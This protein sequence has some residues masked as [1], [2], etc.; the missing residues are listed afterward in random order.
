MAT[1][2]KP[3]TNLKRL[4]KA[5][6]IPKPAKPKKVSILDTDLLPLQEADELLKRIEAQSAE[7][8]I[9]EID[10]EISDDARKTAKSAMVHAQSQLQKLCDARKEQHPLFR[11]PATEAEARLNEENTRPVNVTIT[12][13]ADQHGLPTGQDFAIWLVKPGGLLV[14]GP[15]GNPV[16]ITDLEYSAVESV[17]KLID[18][19]RTSGV[20]S[21][22]NRWS[23]FVA[24][25]TPST[26]P[27]VKEG[28]KSLP[29]E[30]AGI[31]GRG[32]Q[33]LAEAGYGTLG[34]V[35]KLMQDHG[36]GW[37]KEVK[38]IGEETAADIADKFD[39]FWIPVTTTDSDG[40]AV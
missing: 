12:R 20:L 23:K 4:K 24:S 11:Q 30:C 26:N 10:Y 14:M 40:P 6:K 17:A 37:A 27:P 28:W 31:N 32:G 18:E 16:A 2:P 39:E 36:Q 22:A 8:K 13:G 3:K 29:L 38:G 33:L 9:R 19:A 1:K 25:K 35:A 5:N 34:A 7:V 15:T 21:D